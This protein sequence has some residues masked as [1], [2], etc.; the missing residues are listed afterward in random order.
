MEN[1]RIEAINTIIEDNNLLK[2]ICN[3]PYFMMRQLSDA[4][5]QN[6]FD[7]IV[8]VDSEPI[9]NILSRE[10]ELIGY[11]NDCVEDKYTQMFISQEIYNNNTKVFKEYVEQGSYK[12]IPSYN[13]MFHGVVVTQNYFIMMNS[14]V[15][16][17]RFPVFILIDSERQNIK[18]KKTKKSIEFYGFILI[19]YL[20]NPSP[21]TDEQIST[22]ENE[23]K[24]LIPPRIKEMLLK[25]PLIKY[26]NKL[27]YVDL[28]D[29]NKSVITRYTKRVKNMNNITQLKNIDSAET[30]E[31]KE[32]AI[33]ENIQFVSELCDGFLYLGIVSKITVPHDN[34]IALKQSNKL[35]LL[36]NFEEQ[37][38]VDYSFTLWERIVINN[39]VD[40]MLKLY[41]D[42]TIAKSMKSLRKA[43]SLIDI[44]DPKNILHIMKFVMDN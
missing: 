36:L 17:N 41:S 12:I 5:D 11:R 32:L 16:I 13:D 22:F 23:Y 21:Y 27:Y 40:K 14:S 31:E 2:N 34:I 10:N 38:G 7:H 39:N 20:I 19:G 6:V 3:N 15:F 9:E 18:I 43:E 29:A 24:F 4:V 33:E 8:F 30:P 28:F 44:N 35:Y 1:K 26:D 37:Y 42:K 25:Q